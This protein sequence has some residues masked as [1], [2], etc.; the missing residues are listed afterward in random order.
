MRTQINCPLVCSSLIHYPL[1]TGR[2][3]SSRKNAGILVGKLWG[4]CVESSEREDGTIDLFNEDA[5]HYAKAYKDAID[6]QKH[7]GAIYLPRHLH[8]N[9]PPAL[10]QFL[11]D[12]SA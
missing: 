2:D 3:F 5:V 4:L 10:Q 7:G 8:K 12:P 11:F 6:V 9:L 1:N